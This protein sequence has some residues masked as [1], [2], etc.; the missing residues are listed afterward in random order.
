[1]RILICCEFSGVVRD[2]FAARG[3]D[4]YSCDLLPSEK[5]GKHIQ[6]DFRSVIQDSWDFVG[7]HYECKVMSNSGVRWF[8]TVPRKP[9]PGTLYGEARKHA[10][11]EAADIFNITLRD[12]RPGYSENSVMHC[13]AKKLIDREQDQVIQPWYFGVPRFKATCLWFRGG[14]RPLVLTDILTPPAK[15]TLGH[16]IWSAV[17]RASPGENRWMDRSRTFKGVAKAFA[18]QWG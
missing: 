2:A 18:E 3:H 15:G 9:K 6:A 10:L 7:Y 16:K 1:M 12:T 13:H 17:H 11:I 5:P 4:A 8:T 14:V